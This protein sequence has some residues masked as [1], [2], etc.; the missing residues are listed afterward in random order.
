MPPTLQSFLDAAEENFRSQKLEEA[1]K[2]ANMARDHIE[3]FLITYH[4]H[5]ASQRKINGVKDWYAVLGIQDCN[6]DVE[7]IKNAYKK[8]MLKVH[9]DKNSSAAAGDAVKIV[10]KAWKVLSEPTSR[11]A[12]DQIRGSTP[13]RKQHEYDEKDESAPKSYKVPASTSEQ[14]SPNS[15]SGA[16][17]Q[18]DTSACN[19]QSSPLGSSGFEAGAAEQYGTSASQDQAPSYNS[20]AA[21]SANWSATRATNYNMP[22]FKFPFPFPGPWWSGLYYNTIPVPPIYGGPAGWSGS[23]TSYQAPPPNNTPRAGSWSESIRNQYGQG[24]SNFGAAGATGWSCASASSSTHVPAPVNTLTTGL[25]PYCNTQLASTLV[26]MRLAISCTRCN[27]S[28]PL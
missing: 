23:T 22:P 4:V 14:V 6:A 19:S 3:K 16:G 10:R 18:S 7:A 12:Y 28:F 15:E 5:M 26:G 11:Q 8:R 25:C 1:I 20:T 9:P 2:Q 17:V 24:P 13:P 27:W 21:G